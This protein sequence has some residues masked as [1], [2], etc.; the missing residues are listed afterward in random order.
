MSC[1]GR[2]PTNKHEV[3]SA[4]CPRLNR[5]DNSMKQIKLTGLCVIAAIMAI[6]VL[7]ATAA[8]AT[9]P[10]YGRCLKTTGGKYKES[11]CLK[12]SGTKPGS[13]EW[14]PGFVK[15][16]FTTTGGVGVLTTVGGAGVECKSETSGGE[17]APSSNDK[18]ET[19][20]IVHFKGC[21]SLEA[22]CTTPGAASGE[23][24]TNE[25]EGIFG[26]ES[27]ARKKT[28]LELYPAKGVTSGLFIEFSCI[29]LV[30]KVRG[31]VL[32]PIKN[33]TMKAS[34][35]LKFVAKKG[36]QKPEKWEESSEKAIL[37]ASFKAGPFEQAGQ[38]ITATV[39]AEEP[40]E[41]NTAV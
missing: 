27:K 9:A 30:V 1:G 29:G 39:E 24:I 14:F 36:K 20:I 37:E 19:G 10:E 7:A 2:T 33:D 34:E 13:Y 23:L 4:S 28:D 41:L 8:W 40:L 6:G 25:L 32:V 31:H 26:W 18:E 21:K 22:P 38:N 17:F 12:L 35:T 15:Q 16:K 5:M 11:K 3:N